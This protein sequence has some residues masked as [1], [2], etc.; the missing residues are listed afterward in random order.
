M[1]STLIPG[2]EELKVYDHIN[3][4]DVG[5][6]RGSF[7]L[8]LEKI[9]DIEKIYSIGIDPKLGGGHGKYDQFI[10]GCVD[11]VSAPTKVKLLTTG[12]EQ[13]S[14]IC[15]PTE[16]P[17]KFEEQEEEIDVFNLEQIIQEE[18]PDDADIHFLKID[19]EGKDFTILESL[20]DDT[21]SRIVFVA[22]ECVSETPRFEEERL[23]EEVIEYMNS[24][25]F[26]VFHDHVTDN[27]TR[28]SDVIFKNRE[29]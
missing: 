24:K 13:A 17:E 15:K 16:E 27:G 19:A 28:I 6:A 9:V 14:T 2:M 25:K 12:D 18:L 3:V 26:D 8:E 1:S 7:M 23:K 20:S 21:L 4:I 5:A 22:T 11:N 29:K 10:T